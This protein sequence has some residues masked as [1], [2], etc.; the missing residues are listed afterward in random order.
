MRLSGSEGSM[1]RSEDIR[2]GEYDGYESELDAGDGAEKVMDVESQLE[3]VPP[4]NHLFHHVVYD[5]SYKDG[6]LPWYTV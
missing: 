3:V 1:L 4:C 5:V 2:A 6:M